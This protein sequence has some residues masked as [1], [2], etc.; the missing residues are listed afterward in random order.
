MRKRHERSGFTLIEVLVA[1]AIAAL[2]LAALLQVFGTGLRSAAV[3]SRYARAT[4]LA[5]S[6]LSAVGVTSPL[7]PGQYAGADTDGFHWRVSI[8]PY[9]EAGLQAN[10]EIFK[11]QVVVGWGAQADGTR[12]VTLSTLRLGAAK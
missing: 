4:M 2:G 1:F 7:V 3:S 10:I 12:A 6:Q 5:E 9:E 11:V 8:T